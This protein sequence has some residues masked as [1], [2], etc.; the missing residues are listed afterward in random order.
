MSP[1]QETIVEA[2]AGF[3]QYWRDLWKYREL[4]L[5]LAWRDLSVRYK[6]AVLGILWSAL[7]PMIT[8]LVFTIIFGR[9]AQFPSQGAPYPIIV[10]GGLLAWQFFAS[11]LE[12]TSASVIGNSNLVGKVYF[13]RLVIPISSLAVSL[14]DMLINLALLIA[15]MAW[16]QYLPPLRVFLLP[17][18]LSATLFLTL[19]IGFWLS[20]LSAKYRDFR[21]IVPFVVQLGFYASPVGFSTSIVPAH[22]RPLF[23]LNPMVGLIDG[24]RWCLLAQAPRPGATTLATSLLATLLFFVTGLF[25]FRAREREFADVL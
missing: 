5:I 23:D 16:Y 7:R 4:V 1:M 10:L 24:V 8:T 9:L 6:Q 17:L 18:F 21:I 3:R 14:V 11:A 12:S 20:A 13:P 22:W 2:G 25:F 19:G 15:V